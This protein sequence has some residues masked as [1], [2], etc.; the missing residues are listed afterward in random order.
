MFGCLC[1]TSALPRSD[2]FVPR[3][4]KGIFMGYAETLK[5]YIVID[6]ESHSFHVSRDVRFIEHEFPFKSGSTSNFLDDLFTPFS[7]DY[8]DCGDHTSHDVVVDH[9][10]DSF[11]NDHNI[12]LQNEV[13][14]ND[15][16]EI[17][18]LAAVEDSDIQE[19][20][21]ISPKT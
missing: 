14:Y 12:D 20:E 18:I 17:T 11:H 13:L 16:E 9:A 19:S 8:V 4:R 6:L 1:F 7:Q 15:S 2:K 10:T 21:D 5:G 3:A